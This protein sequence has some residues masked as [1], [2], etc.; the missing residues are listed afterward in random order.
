MAAIYGELAMQAAREN[1]THEAFLYELARQEADYRTQ[2]R[3]VRQIREAG[4]PSEK[5]FQT[6]QVE[7]FDRVQTTWVR[8]D[9]VFYSYKVLWTER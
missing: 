9:D 3:I 2:R 8:G 1:D 4:L 5:T 7:V 6:L